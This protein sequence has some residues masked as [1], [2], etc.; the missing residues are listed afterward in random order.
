MT[1]LHY[2]MED[3]ESVEKGKHNVRGDTANLIELSSARG[4]QHDDDTDEEPEQQ[5]EDVA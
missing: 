5:I 3:E 1:Q 2:S 4:L